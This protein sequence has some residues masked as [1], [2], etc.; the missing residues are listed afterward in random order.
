MGQL[1]LLD[2][3]IAVAG[4]LLLATVGYLRVRAELLRLRREMGPRLVRRSSRVA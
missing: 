3:A 4:F 2:E 1:L